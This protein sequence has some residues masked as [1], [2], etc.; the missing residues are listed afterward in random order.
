MIWFTANSGD[1][2][3][4][5]DSAGRRDRRASWL[6]EWTHTRA[7]SRNRVLCPS[8]PHRRSV[9]S[10]RG[11]LGSRAPRVCPGACLLGPINRCSAGCVYRPRRGEPSR[12]SAPRSSRSAQDIVRRRARSRSLGRVCAGSSSQCGVLVRDRCYVAITLGRTRAAS[13]ERAVAGVERSHQRTWDANDLILS[14]T[15]PTDPKRLS[16][17]RFHEQSRWNSSMC[18]RVSL[19]IQVKTARAALRYLSPPSLARQPLRGFPSVTSETRRRPFPIIEGSPLDPCFQNPGSGVRLTP[20]AR[21]GGPRG[22][23]GRGARPH[24][25]VPPSCPC[26]HGGR[27]NVR[28]EVPRE[29]LA[30]ASISSRRPFDRSQPD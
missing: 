7:H 19:L 2:A 3:Q 16:A 17:V 29:P 1:A 26:A 9:V 24:P 18:L 30:G 13:A 5:L 25:S 21:P 22:R 23:R 14:D 6:L 12:R 4:A 11:A 28:S 10:G 27:A 8:H 20:G 15:R